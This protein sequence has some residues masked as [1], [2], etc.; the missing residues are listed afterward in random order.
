MSRALVIGEALID[1][2]ERNGRITGEHVGG[3]PLNVAVGLARLERDVDFLTHIASD[4]RGN[5][6]VEYLKSSGVQ[7]VSGSRTAARTPTAV[8]TLDDTG[9]ARYTFDIDWQL[10]GTP[11]V[12]PPLVAHTGSIATVLEPGCRA[13]AALLD[14]YHLSATLTFDPNVRTALISDDEAARNRIERLVERCDVV[15]AS[16]EDMRWIDPRRSPEQIAQTWL[17]MGPS[18]V[19]VTMGEQ[20]GFAV[21]RAGVVRVPSRPV[22]VVDTVGAGDAFMTGLIDGLW[23]LDLLGAQR[24][25]DLAAISTDALTEVLSTA[26]LTSALTVAKAGADLPDRAARDAAAQGAQG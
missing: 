8:A 11:E 5:R 16:D 15:K 3:S 9:S 26:V 6:I 12:A 24:R 10:A 4:D 13:V 1:I 20:G 2:V 17:N 23:S 14:A 18:I 22:Q 19:A 7:L 25:R 21:C